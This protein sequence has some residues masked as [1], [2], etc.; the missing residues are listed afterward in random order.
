MPTSK[1]A[2]LNQ[3]KEEGFGVKVADGG[4]VAH[5]SSDKPSRH[6]LVDA[7]PKLEDY[8][9]E[10]TDEGVFIPIGEERFLI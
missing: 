4:I 3:L 1:N 10:T 8:P 7:V 6:E 2:L 5:L 9:M